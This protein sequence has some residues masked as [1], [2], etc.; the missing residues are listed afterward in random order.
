[1]TLHNRN[2][3][4][5]NLKEKKANVASGDFFFLPVNRESVLRHPRETTAKLLL[6]NIPASS[7]SD[8]P[9]LDPTTFCAFLFQRRRLFCPLPPRI[10]HWADRFSTLTLAESPLELGRAARCVRLG[11]GRQPSATFGRLRRCLG[12]GWSARGDVQGRRAV[13]GGGGEVRS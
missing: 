12:S 13:V 5:K 11:G 2:T 6:A 9:A 3:E 1:M 10:K 4:S 7:L 8:T